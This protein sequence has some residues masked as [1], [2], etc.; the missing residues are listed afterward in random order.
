M[1]NTLYLPELREMLAENNAAELREFCLALHPARTAEF[2]EGLTAA[3]A[4]EV[5]RHTDPVTRMEIFSYFPPERQI[6]TIQSVDRNEVVRLIADLPSDERVDILDSVDP[7]IVDELLTLLP[8]D[9]RRDILR[10]RSY[11]DESA[12]A[13]MTT[14]FARLS[15]RQTVAEA[16]EALRRQS[17]ELETVYYLYVVDDGDHLRG[18]VSLRDMILSKPTAVIGD[19]MERAVV[20]VDVT[21]DQEE[22]ARKLARFDFVA[23]PVIDHEHH[24]VGIVTHD[25]VIDVVRDEA[26]EDAQ[27]IAGVEPLRMGYLETR[28]A[29]LTWKRGL[30]LTILFLGATGTILTLRTY[31]NITAELKWLVLFLP[32]II[33]SGGN[34]GSQS[35]TLIITALST[36]DISLADWWR[37]VRRELLMG[38]FLGGFL[39]LIGSTL[40]LVSSPEPWAVAIVPLT[41]ILVVTCGTLVGSILPLVFSRI[42]LDPALMSNPFV[43]CICDVLGT[44][45]YLEVAMF[46]LR[47]PRL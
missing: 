4:W 43:S 12:G 25:D 26:T 37:V 27:R 33:S 10:L 15:E 35:A 17:E 28:L 13:I 24:L 44:I 38:L 46:V 9:E 29:T 2:M 41:L 45:I 16:L 3:E 1:T 34:S 23:I 40:A 18:L 21:D 7:K 47:H 20:S 42:G 31:E 19:I 6:E 32:L 5:L 14:Q 22:V 8:P 36:G 39:G 30:W 11:P